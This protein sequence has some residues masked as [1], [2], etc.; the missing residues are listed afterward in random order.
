MARPARSPSLDTWLTR[1]LD[2]TEDAA[3]HRVLLE[4]SLTRAGARAAALWARTSSGWRA[5]AAL[6]E[7]ELLP[8]APRARAVLEDSG[9]AA[10][11]AGECVLAPAGRRL[12]LL[13]AGAPDDDA[14]DEL[15]ALLLVRESMLDPHALELPPLPRPPARE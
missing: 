15:E 2:G 7:V 14:L 12:A 11:R 5:L 4:A 9:E 13:L 6:G 10:L 3:Q 8:E 1:L